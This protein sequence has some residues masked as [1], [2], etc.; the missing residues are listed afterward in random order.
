MSTNTAYF[1]SHELLS[2]VFQGHYND[3]TEPGTHDCWWFTGI[4]FLGQILI[5][6][7]CNLWSYKK[8]LYVTLLLHGFSFMAIGMLIILL[9]PFKFSKI[10]TYHTTAIYYG[11]R[12]NFYL[13]NSSSGK[14][15]YLDGQNIDTINWLQFSSCYYNTDHNN[16]RCIQILHQINA[17]EFGRNIVKEIQSLRT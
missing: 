17:T 14:C 9:K 12:L 10:S 5:L 4:Y 11:N 15:S 1:L 6:Y 3:G 8:M 7:I 13:I 16:L 2:K